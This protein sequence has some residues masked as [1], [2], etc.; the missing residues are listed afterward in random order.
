MYGYT[1]GLERSVD[2]NMIDSQHRKSRREGANLFRCSNEFA[3]IVQMAVKRA[4]WSRPAQTVEIAKQDKWSI[5]SN[6]CAPLGAGK[7][8]CLNEAFAPA[9]TEM[10]IDDVNLPEIGFNIHFNR[11]AIL[12]AEKRW[13]AW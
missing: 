9:E 8:L 6:G 11:R 12:P 13:S 2:E 10:R 1:Q 5:T 4:I 7:Q 3:H